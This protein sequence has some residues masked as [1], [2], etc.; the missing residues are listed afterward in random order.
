VA[1]LFSHAA[2][3]VIIHGASTCIGADYPGYAVEAVRRLLGDDVLALFVQGCAGDCNGEPLRG[4]FEAARRAG[5]ILGAAAAKAALEAEAIGTDRIV[6]LA[7]SFPVPFRPP[8]PLD[9]IEDMLRGDKLARL[10]LEKSSDAATK[11]W[12]DDDARCCLEQVLDIA[13]SGEVPSL[14][15]RVQGFALDAEFG[16]VALSHEPFAEFQ[17]AADRVSSFRHTLVAGY[18]NGIESYIPRDE[19]LESGGYETA[20]LPLPGA[21]LRYKHRLNLAPGVEDRVKNGVASFLEHLASE[22]RERS[23]S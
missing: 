21:P 12:Y 22:T 13:R 16:L 5:T 20:P 6:S 10:D 2:H 19:D 14:E 17:L 1:V 3:P 11:K 9:E 23:A 8:P 4:G 7:E 18:V 15:F